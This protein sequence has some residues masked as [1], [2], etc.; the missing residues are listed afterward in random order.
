MV[1]RTSW[2]ELPIWPDGTRLKVSVCTAFGGCRA[3]LTL[4]VLK[5]GNAL[6]GQSTNMSAL[7]AAPPVGMKRS[8]EMLDGS[9]A[10]S[11]NGSL[12]SSVVP[13]FVSETENE[14]WVRVVLLFGATPVIRFHW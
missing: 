3:K 14:P 2:H 9:V 1:R 8:S 10:V 12:L 6:L 5:Q 7:P 4:P 11:T 13:G